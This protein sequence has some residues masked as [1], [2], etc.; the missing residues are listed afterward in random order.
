MGLHGV[1]GLLRVRGMLVGVWAWGYGCQKVLDGRK[2]VVVVVP[3]AVGC[4]ASPLGG[5]RGTVWLLCRGAVYGRV[6][7]SCGWR[8]ARSAFSRDL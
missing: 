2:D 6:G 7:D 8:C 5:S 3:R 4:S 1:V